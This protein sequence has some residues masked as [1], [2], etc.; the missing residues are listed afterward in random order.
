LWAAQ[1]CQA[2]LL[3]DVDECPVV[4]YSQLEGFPSAGLI[5]PENYLFDSGKPRAVY[6]DVT[7]TCLL[8]FEKVS[9]GV[10]S[11]VVGGQVRS[12]VSSSVIPGDR[13]ADVP[14]VRTWQQGAVK[15]AVTV[16]SKLAGFEVKSGL[17]CSENGEAGEELCVP[18]K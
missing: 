15:K 5:R 13:G 2:S 6:I 18:R 10:S 4:Q 7:R 3:F 17:W 9:A 1:P 11:E 8:R 14:D 12:A 16:N